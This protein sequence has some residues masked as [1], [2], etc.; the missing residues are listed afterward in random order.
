LVRNFAFASLINSSWCSSNSS[1]SLVGK[2]SQVG[3]MMLLGET[4]E[5]SFEL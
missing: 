4:L 5:L 1:C 3:S 2:M